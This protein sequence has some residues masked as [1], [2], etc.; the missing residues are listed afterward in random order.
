[1]L[2]TFQRVEQPS[3][4]PIENVVVGEHT[5][6]DICRHE[7]DGVLRTHS[8]VD[9]FRHKRPSARDAGFEIDDP[10]VRLH[11]GQLLQSRAPNIRELDSSWDSSVHLLGEA[12]IV[13]G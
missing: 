3:M 5:A 2:Q 1:M 6:I 7:A 4:P 8:I 11:A 13:S 12:D 10:Y 9:A